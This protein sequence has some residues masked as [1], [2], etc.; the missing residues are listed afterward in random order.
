MVKDA[1][2]A[3]NEELLSFSLQWMEASGI[4]HSLERLFGYL[5]RRGSNLAASC[6]QFRT[7]SSVPA[8]LSRRWDLYLA[9]P[10]QLNS[11]WR[12]LSTA[13]GLWDPPIRTPTKQDPPSSSLTPWAELGAAAS[14]CWALHHTPTWTDRNTCVS[15]RAVATSTLN[16]AVWPETSHWV[17]PVAMRSTKSCTGENS[18]F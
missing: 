11:I 1:D 3:V 15:C 12:Q 7:V 14:M 6:Y 5:W 16:Y 10:P 4:S 17:T 9:L 18:L 2:G 13:R 8:P